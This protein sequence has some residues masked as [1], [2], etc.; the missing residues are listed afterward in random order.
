MK[1]LKYLA[2]L[3]VLIVDK[4]KINE[5]EIMLFI[6]KSLND[7]NFKKLKLNFEDWN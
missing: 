4:N 5:D 1:M 6:D 3:N 2:A 7:M